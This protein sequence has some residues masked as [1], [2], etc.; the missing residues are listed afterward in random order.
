MPGQFQIA[1]LIANESFDLAL[2]AG[3]IAYQDGTYQ[4]FHDTFFNVYKSWMRSSH[5][6]VNR[7]PRR[8]YF[9]GASLSR[10]LRAARK[11]RERDIPDHKERYYSFNY[12][13][14]HFVAL[15]SELAF[16]DPARTAGASELA[17]ER[18]CKQHATV[19][20]RVFHRPPYS[21]GFHGSDAQ[22]QQA[23]G[24]IFEQ[25]GVQLV[26]NGHEHNYERLVP[27]RETGPQA[28]TYVVTGGGRSRVAHGWAIGV[29]G[30]G[31]VS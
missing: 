18:S 3:D 4:Q 26:I 21:S 11:R 28:V 30:C 14:I 12:G 19:A 25:R 15:D 1:N 27:W 9:L 10:T 2:H 6:S 20:H 16:L 8:P 29:Y 22:L 31:A 23:F 24:P 17:G 5:L 13:P 7:K